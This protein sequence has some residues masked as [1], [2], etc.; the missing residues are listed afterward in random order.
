MLKDKN[1]RI[2]MKKHFHEQRP[3][4]YV[5][6]VTSFSENWIILHARTLMAARTQPNGV[7]MDAKASAVMLPRENIDSI[8]ILPDNFDADS[9]RITT[10][11]QQLRIAVEGA[12]DCFIAEMG[13]G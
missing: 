3:I 12:Q 2:K 6:K 1:V 4:S 13:E 5:G 10:E 7:Q 8:R 11:G 9:I